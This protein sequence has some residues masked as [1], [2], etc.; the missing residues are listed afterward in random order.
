MNPISLSY[1]P[2]LGLLVL[3]CQPS[4]FTWKNDLPSL[5]GSVLHTPSSKSAS[6]SKVCRTLFTHQDWILN[7]P[8]IQSS[9]GSYSSHRADFRKSRHSESLHTSQKSTQDLPSNPSIRN[10]IWWWTHPHHPFGAVRWL[11]QSSPHLWTHFL[12]Q[13]HP[14]HIRRFYTESTPLIT[15]HSKRLKTWHR[16]LHRHHKQSELLLGDP[17]WACHPQKLFEVI[18]NQFIPFQKSAQPK[19]RFDG[20]YLDL[21]PH[22]LN[23]S[24]HQ[25]PFKWD[26]S[27]SLLKQ[28]LLYGLLYALIKVRSLL[29]PSERLSVYLPFWFDQ[30]DQETDLWDSSLQRDFYF[31][32]L[33]EQVDSMTIAGYCRSEPRQLKQ[34]LDWELQ[35]YPSQ[36]R[37]GLNLGHVHQHSICPTWKDPHHLLRNLDQLRRLHYSL[38]TLPIDFENLIEW[39]AFQS[40]PIK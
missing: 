4:Q 12:A 22:A 23:E 19:E 5:T 14:L 20:I 40:L 7:P 3:G 17:Q 16:F 39:V 18:Q 21:E 2:L 37:L 6:L 15:T 36:V 11:T 24:S 32:C 26:Q 10:G 33:S 30:L 38:S 29:S 8:S 34:V 25:C 27:S 9:L 1:L 13:L 28:D 31:Q 35:N